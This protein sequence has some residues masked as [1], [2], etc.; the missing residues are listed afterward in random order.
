MVHRPPLRR[1]RHA[2][3]KTRLFFRRY[4]FLGGSSSGA[5]SGDPLHVPLVAGMMAMDQKR[6]QIANVLSAV[7]WAPAMFAPGWLGMKGARRA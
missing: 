1:Y 5:S 3:A 4:G 7:V 6:F 2:V